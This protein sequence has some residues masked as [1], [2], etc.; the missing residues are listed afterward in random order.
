MKVYILTGEY[1]DYD[2]WSTNYSEVLGVY[3]KEEDAIIS[4][5]E[6]TKEEIETLNSEDYDIDSDYMT[7]IFSPVGGKTTY[8]IEEKEVIFNV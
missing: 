4:L 1:Q 2:D 7:E 6:H 8:I 3:A 5:K